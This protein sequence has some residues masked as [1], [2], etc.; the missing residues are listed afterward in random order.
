MPIANA[1]RLLKE[2]DDSPELRRMFYSCKTRQELDF[3]LA[4]LAMPFTIAEFEE[5]INGEHVK[6]QTAEQAA[7]LMHKAEWFRMI[8]RG[9]AEA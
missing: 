2:I 9:L 4:S 8:Y 6:C 5:S 3:C 7:E 1:V